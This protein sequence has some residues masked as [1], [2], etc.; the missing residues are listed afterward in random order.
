M[1]RRTAPTACRCSASP[2]KS[3]PSTACRCVSRPHRRRA[4]CARRP[5]AVPQ[6]DVRRSH[7]RARLCVRATSA[8]RPTSR[9]RPSP[10]W[11]QRRLTALGVRPISNVVDITNYVLLELGQPMHAFDFD[12][13]A[14]A[15]IVVRR[16]RAGETLTTLDGKARTLTTEML[17]IADAEQAAAI[18]G[19]MGGADSEVRDVHRAS[20]SRPRGSSRSRCAPRA[21][22]SASAAEASM[23]FE[24]G[25]DLSHC[26]ARWRGRAGCSSSSA[27]GERLGRWSTPTRSLSRR[28]SCRSPT[29]TS[30]RCSGCLCRT[31]DVERILNAL[32]FARE[33]RTPDAA[34]GAS[35]SRL[36]PG[37]RAT[38]GSH[39]GDRTPPRVRA[40]ARDLP[41]GASG[42]A[43]L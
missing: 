17:V 37:R 30:R 16:A 43:A 27:P 23:R 1:S 21:S 39:R 14:G 42:A 15:T 29:R 6:D 28:G 26:A 11:M 18:G 9:W 36:A 19:V 5:A 8:R 41:T 4:T 10:A 25:A 13:L 32:G 20:S 2:A 33:R 12:R 38:R 3:P 24:R 40:P 31:T 22:G 34:R 7:R 35:R